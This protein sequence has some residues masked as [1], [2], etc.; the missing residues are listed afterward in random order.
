MEKATLSYMDEKEM[1]NAR[2]KDRI[3]FNAE[4]R[5]NDAQCIV[6]RDKIIQ[7]RRSEEYMDNVHKILEAVIDLS[8]DNIKSELTKNN[9]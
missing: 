3:V 9:K 2:V 7:A 8:A 4:R 6:S 1:L 5:K